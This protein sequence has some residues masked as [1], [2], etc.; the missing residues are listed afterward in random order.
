M[1]IKVISVGRKTDEW[2]ESLYSRFNQRIKRQCSFE[3]MVL[4]PGK[5]S[6]VKQAEASAIL[7]K[8]KS[9]SVLILLDETGSLISSVE[10]SRLISENAMLSKDI[11]FV[12][13]GAHGVSD[14]IKQKAHLTIALSKMTLP[15]QLARLIL[16]EQLYRA[17]CILNN[18]PY[19]HE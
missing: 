11:S 17:N 2:Y 14:E 8:I 4:S 6:A 18:H 5:G 15:H 12:I 19:H 9:N 1:H 13:G 7:A 16:L 10:L 3:E